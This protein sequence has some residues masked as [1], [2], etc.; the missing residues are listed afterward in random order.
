MDVGIRELKQR[1][2]EILDLVA[3][4]ETVRVTDRGVP[5]ALLTPALSADRLAIGIEEG[6]VRAPRREGQVGRGPRM[7]S[8]RRVADVLA[9]DRED[10]V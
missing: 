10:R 6:W 8:D 5:K 2:S 1:L 3:K 4:G 9:E 7:K